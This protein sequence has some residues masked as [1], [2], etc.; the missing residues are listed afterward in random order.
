MKH[1]SLRTTQKLLADGIDEAPRKKR[2]EE[3]FP[4]DCENAF[5]LGARLVEEQQKISQAIY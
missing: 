1:I 3:V 5:N 4:I 2:R